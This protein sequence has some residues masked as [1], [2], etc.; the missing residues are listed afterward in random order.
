[1]QETQGRFLGWKDHLEKLLATQSS[2]LAWRIPWTEEP[3]G[4]QSM[5]SQRVGHN[6]ATNTFTFN[7]S[8]ISFQHDIKIKTINNVFYIIF[9]LFSLFFF[10]FTL[11]FISLLNLV[12]DIP[13]QHISIQV[14][15]IM[16]SLALLLDTAY[17]KLRE[18][19]EAVIQMIQSKLNKQTN[20]LFFA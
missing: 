17:L 6:W 4:L 15:H 10:I 19:T 13:L 20:T 12:Y 18:K 7:I 1:M 11:F 14:S 9:F 8:K 3:G 2:I 5:G 16:S